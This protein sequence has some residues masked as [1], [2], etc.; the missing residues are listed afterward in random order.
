M[1]FPDNGAYYTF[2]LDPVAS[3]Q[4]IDDEEVAEAARRISPKVYVAC[5]IKTIGAPQPPPAYEVATIALVQQGLPPESPEDFLESRITRVRIRT[6]NRNTYPPHSLGPSECVTLRFLFGD[7]EQRRERLRDCAAKGIAP[8]PPQPSSMTLASISNA[9]S[10]RSD[11]PYWQIMAARREAALSEPPLELHVEIDENWDAE[12]DCSDASGDSDGGSGDRGD[13]PAPTIQLDNEAPDDVARERSPAVEDVAEVENDILAALTHRADLGNTSPVIVPLSYDLSTLTAPPSPTRFMEEL[14]AIRKIR[15]DYEERVRR[16]KQEVQRRDGEYMADIQKRR[17]GEPAEQSRWP[18]LGGFVPFTNKVKAR[19]EDK[20]VA[21]AARRL[22]T[23]K[24]VACLTWPVGAPQLPPAYEVANIDLVQQGL[25]PAIPEDFRESRMCVPILPNTQ[26][27]DG[28]RTA[29]CCHPLPWDGCY[30]VAAHRTRVR[31]KTEVRPIDPPHSLAPAECVLL[32]HTLED[33]EERRSRLRECA[34]KGLPPPPVAAGDYTISAIRAA[35][36]EIADIPHWQIRAAERAE[37]LANPPNE[38]AFQMKLKPNWDAD[39]DSSNYSESDDGGHDAP[40]RGSAHSENDVPD[41]AAIDP[42]ATADDIADVEDVILTTLNHRADLR[43]LSP[44]I[45]PL[46]YDLSGLS[47]PPSP[48]GFMEELDAIRKIRSDYEERIRRLK[49]E[50]RLRDDEYMADIEARRTK[51]S[52]A[53]SRWSIPSC[54]AP[55]ANKLKARLGSS[56][57]TFPYPG[58]YYTFRLDP[59][60]SL[61]DIEDQAVLKAAR[62]LPTKVYVASTIDNTG[63][64]Q[65][66]PAYSVAT[67]SLVQQG[68]PHDISENFLESRMC[69]PIRP[70]TQ[71]PD[72]R[73]PAHCC[74]PLPWDGCYHVARTDVRIR[75][76]TRPIDPPHSLGPAERVALVAALRY[77]EERRECLRDCAVKGIPPPPAA[78][79]GRALAA[80]RVADREISNTPHWQIM[81]A[82]AEANRLACGDADSVYSDAASHSDESDDEVCS[83]GSAHMGGDAEYGTTMDAQAAYGVA[84]VEDDIL[85][86]LMYRADLGN[87]SPVIVP[88]SYD[89]SN[90]TAP[91]SPSGFMDELDAIRKLRSDYEERV[92]MLKEEVQRRDDEYMADIQARRTGESPVQFK[93]PL[94]GG[95]VPFTNKVKARVGA[96]VM[97]SCF[98]S[99]DADESSAFAP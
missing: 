57:M 17:I 11:V 7:D 70:N 49:D 29:H 90:W 65:P 5:T 93:W 98:S 72:G 20:Q 64:P 26:H 34:A 91:P 18:L 78:P 33:D 53:R 24:Y 62:E 96:Y 73:R 19:L 41:N 76:E 42:A 75:T 48:T 55:F 16:L 6:E 45:V 81:E 83:S 95:F 13:P 1:S 3:L 30:H 46:S 89:L 28:R 80:A 77:D 31:I 10:N 51:Q 37:R 36:Q 50:V 38:G 9:D 69:V 67:I 21:K 54:F 68:L 43:D 15:S 14:E 27:P 59:V 44:V 22:S 32:N 74:H 84:E 63:A 99:T 94:L 52:P 23:K 4:D 97:L 56:N 25:L 61:R 85:A 39:S 58:S 40:V 79:S 66:P 12:T 88:L 71:H 2:H 60:A 87:T 47:A 8:P 86:A 92:R 35:D 82:K